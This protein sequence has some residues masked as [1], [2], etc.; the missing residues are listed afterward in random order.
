MV[1]ER[2]QPVN[3]QQLNAPLL[4]LNDPPEG[5]IKANVFS[6]AST[7]NI[8][9]A[10]VKSTIE[11]TFGLILTSPITP[12]PMESSYTTNSFT[13]KRMPQKQTANPFIL[14]LIP[15]SQIENPFTFKPISQK[16]TANSVTTK[17]MLFNQRG[18]LATSRS[19]PVKQTYIPLGLPAHQSIAVT[20]KQSLSNLTTN[21]PYRVKLPDNQKTKPL[22][23]DCTLNDLVSSKSDYTWKGIVP[24]SSDNKVYSFEDLVEQEKKY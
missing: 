7:F 21:L 16:Q 5:V 20:P 4:D 13:F 3:E 24:E 14:E 18:N 8:V 10:S 19:M 1:G 6:I 15:Y 23:I 11:E 2:E 22:L 9:E 12:K 17:P